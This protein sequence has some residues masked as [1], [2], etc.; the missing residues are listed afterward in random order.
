[1]PILRSSRGDRHLVPASHV[2][3]PVLIRN[4]GFDTIRRF[5]EFFTAS[6]RNANTR[7][8]YLRAVRAF[9]SWAERRR[10]TLEQIEPIVVAAYVE[11]L[12]AKYSKLTVKQHLAAIRMMFDFFVTGGI[13][14]VNPAASV[15]GPKVTILKGTTP[16]LSASEARQLLDSIDTRDLIGLRDRA[17]IGL[18]VFS[19]SRIGAALKMRVSDIRIKDGRHWVRLHEKGGRHHEMPLNR[20]AEQYLLAY[21]NLA[22][23]RQ[24]PTTPLFRSIGRGG[25]LRERVLHRNDALRMVKRRTLAA[26]L[27]PHICCHTF[28][29]TGITEYMRNGGTLEKAQ[30]MAAHASSRTTNLY[31][32]VRDDVSLDEVERVLI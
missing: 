14:R 6:I 18:L 4:A 2:P 1:M 22:G 9:C 26:G 10:I 20:K 19:F 28:R 31:N 30:Q 12:M 15:K 13:L 5:V 27:S 29:A 8:A 16:I 23:L 24:E 25:I 21:I 3:V 11:E 32:R 7:L 17:L